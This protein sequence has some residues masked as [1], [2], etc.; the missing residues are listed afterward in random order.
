MFRKL[1]R[2]WSIGQELLRLHK[3]LK[4]VTKTMPSFHASA[5]TA[6]EEDMQTNRTVIIEGEIIETRRDVEHSGEPQIA[7]EARS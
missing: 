5:S 4:E 3:Q 2:W 1:K 6:H 7:T